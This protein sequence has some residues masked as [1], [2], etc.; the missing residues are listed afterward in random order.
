MTGPGDVDLPS[1]AEARELLDVARLGARAAGAKGADIDDVAQ[2]VAER[3]TAKWSAVHVVAARNRGRRGWHA[4]IARS[5]KNEYRDLG[6]KRLR[7]MRRVH[8]IA[9]GDGEPLVDRPGVHRP[10]RSGPSDVDRY[11]GRRI[12]ADLIDEVPGLNAGHRQVLVLHLL[13]GLST[14]EIAARLDLSIREVNR[15]KQHGLAVLRAAVIER[16]Q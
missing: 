14:T 13:D 10:P 11:L 3:L 8:R 12:I 15:R 6:R 16:Q 7:E 4:Y 2:A 5:A 9:H 1:P